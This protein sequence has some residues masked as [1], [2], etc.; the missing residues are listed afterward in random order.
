MCQD[1]V[2]SIII[3]RET[4]RSVAARMA[5]LAM[6]DICQKAPLL[7]LA[8]ASRSDEW[9]KDFAVKILRIRTEINQEIESARTCGHR[10]WLD[11]LDE[12]FEKSVARGRVPGIRANRPSVLNVVNKAPHPD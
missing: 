6:N 10:E 7:P 4:P 2:L 12:P 8:L 5:I 3:T 9:V 1:E 11:Y